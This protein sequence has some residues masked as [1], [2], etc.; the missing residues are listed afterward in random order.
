[1]ADATGGSVKGKCWE[2]GQVKPVREEQLSTG[3]VV[4]LCQDCAGWDE[5][6]DNA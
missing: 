4:R 3:E 1:M 6:D 5:E 2:C